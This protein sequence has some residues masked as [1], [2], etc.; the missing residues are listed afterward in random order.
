ML[1][2]GSRLASAAKENQLFYCFAFGKSDFFL[3]LFFLGFFSFF[4]LVSPDYILGGYKK[5]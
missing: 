5:I 3:D 4:F 2:L 1:T